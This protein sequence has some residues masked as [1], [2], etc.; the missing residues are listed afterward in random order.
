MDSL[1]PGKPPRQALMLASASDTCILCQS[2]QHMQALT[3]VLD[4][5]SLLCICIMLWATDK[6]D[7]L[8][9]TAHDLYRS[10]L[11]I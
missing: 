5:A 6:A 9:F 11:P 7:A 1:R 3:L 8:V 10:A 4:T 2:T